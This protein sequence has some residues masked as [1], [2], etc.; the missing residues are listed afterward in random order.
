MTKMARHG[1]VSF[2]F[3]R[4]STCR[5]GVSAE[6]LLSL[7][8]MPVGACG[9]VA[10]HACTVAKDSGPGGGLRWLI[11]TTLPDDCL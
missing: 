5:K 3:F 9:S 4:I 1:A 11:K 10:V 6:R 8:F 2:R 7:W